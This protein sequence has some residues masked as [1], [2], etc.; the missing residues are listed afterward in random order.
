[1][2]YFSLVL[3]C[4]NIILGSP[5]LSTPQNNILNSWLHEMYYQWYRSTLKGLTVIT[6]KSL[7]KQI[8]SKDY[9]NLSWVIKAVLSYL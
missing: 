2:Q 5:F 8:V 1:M 9:S 7:S 3:C 6:T 4:Y